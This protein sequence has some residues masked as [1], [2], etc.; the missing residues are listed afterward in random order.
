VA[1]VAGGIALIFSARSTDGGWLTAL[2]GM[3]PVA[4]WVIGL[5]LSALLVVT[6][7]PWLAQ[8]FDFVPLSPTQWIAA[9][10][11]GLLSFVPIQLAKQVAT[12]G[13]AVA[14]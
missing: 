9:C 3:A 2:R 12:R 8:Q 10:A 11:A 5:T 4:R 6:S 13:R 7:W 14:A 1:L